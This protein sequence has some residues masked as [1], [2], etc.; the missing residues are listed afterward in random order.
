M[1]DNPSTDPIHPLSKPLVLKVTNRGNR[2]S[3]QVKVN[4]EKCLL[5]SG[6]HADIHIPE[7]E[8]KEIHC[9]FVRNPVGIYVRQF[10]D[11][12]LINGLSLTEA[13]VFPGD[14]IQIANFDIEI[15]EVGQFVLE[16][17][18]N[19]QNRSP[20]NPL[21]ERVAATVS[22]NHSGYADRDH[23]AGIDHDQATDGQ[24]FP[25]RHGGSPQDKTPD[26]DTRNLEVETTERTSANQRS[27][28]PQDSLGP[29]PERATRLLDEIDKAV[30]EVAAD[31]T[32]SDESQDAD[33]KPK[34]KRFESVADVVS[35]MQ[36]AGKLDPASPGSE[37]TVAPA[38]QSGDGQDSDATPEEDAEEG[39]PAK[40]GDESVQDYMN[41]LMQRLRTGADEEEKKESVDSVDRHVGLDTEAEDD[42]EHEDLTPENPLRPG[43]FV[44]NQIAPE[45]TTTLDAL[46]QVAN[47][48]VDSAIKRSAREKN[49][50]TNS[51]YLGAATVCLFI[52]TVLFMFSTNVLDIP[53]IAAMLFAVGCVGWS[54]RYLSANLVGGKTP[55]HRTKSKRVKAQK[56]RAKG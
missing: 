8:V 35:R 48:A 26:S 28:K 42:E 41:Q 27:D 46:R 22:S 1:L 39:A 9:E 6:D 33:A 18:S 53:F 25:G 44:P 47:Q 16:P 54:F 17:A 10:G 4:Q 32:P 52:S 14:K 23:G 19:T 36:K 43:E 38:E 3:E 29:D 37:A 51:I 21:Q 45:K 12:I 7:P 2:T 5:G 20:V 31:S 24:D 15:V 30:N 34:K 40:E 49:S 11:E 55:K 50:E 56:S 13:W